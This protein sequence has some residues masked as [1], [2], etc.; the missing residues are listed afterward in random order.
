MTTLG[1]LARRWLVILLGVALTA[2]ACWSVLH[3]VGS[4][5]QA[6]GQLVLL[7]PPDSTGVDSPSNPYNNLQPDLD[8]VAGVVAGSVMSKDTEARLVTEGFDAEY[9]VA[10]APGNG[11]LLVITTMDKDPGIAVSTRDAVLREIGAE[12]A[13]MQQAANAPQQQLISASAS[14]VSPR[15]EVLPGSRLRALAGTATAGL[16]LTLVLAFG[17]DRLRRRLSE[18]RRERHLAGELGASDLVLDEPQHVTA[19]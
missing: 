15:A 5:F 18:W 19:G 14:S 4:D 1:V 13:A 12:L 7:L 16:L 17:V 8:T 2:M 11:P 6:S 10:V 9:D 3:R